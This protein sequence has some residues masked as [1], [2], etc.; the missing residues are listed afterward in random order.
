MSGSGASV[1]MWM[2]CGA[3]PTLHRTC[4]HHTRRMFD[5]AVYIRME[6]IS[7]LKKYRNRLAKTHR[8]T[9]EAADAD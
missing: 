3:W 5:G 4:V 2:R 9:E 6:P 1:E 8:R 7:F